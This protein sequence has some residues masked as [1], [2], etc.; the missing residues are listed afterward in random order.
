MRMLDVLEQNPNAASLIRQHYTSLLK[1]KID[2]DVDY[3]EEFKNFINDFELVNEKVVDLIS[4][5]PRS[6]FDFF[7]SDDMASFTWSYHPSW[8]PDSKI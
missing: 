4:S 3:S 1:D 2:A 6:L 5:A 7:D 8:I